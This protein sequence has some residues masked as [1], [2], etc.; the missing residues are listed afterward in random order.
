MSRKEEDFEQL[1]R[2]RDD[3]IEALERFVTPADCDCE[4]DDVGDVPGDCN[5]CLAR[6]AILAAKVPA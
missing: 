4:E 3:L 6:D 2:I 5:F 1:E